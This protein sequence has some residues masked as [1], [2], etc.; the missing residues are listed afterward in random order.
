VTHIV[1]PKANDSDSPRTWAHRELA[2][3]FPKVAEVGKGR[4]PFE[5]LAPGGSA[6]GN[7]DFQVRAI[8]AYNTILD[9][10]RAVGDPDAGVLECAYAERSWP[11]ELTKLFGHLTGIMVRIASAQSGALPDDDDARAVLEMAHATR[12]ASDVAVYGRLRLRTL[13]RAAERRFARAFSA[14]QRQ[15]GRMS[16]ILLTLE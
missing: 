13:E 4:R 7:L 16:S 10:L 15:R 6:P 14:Y 3:F 1:L 12:L 5:V 9:R 11:R 8:R 2:W